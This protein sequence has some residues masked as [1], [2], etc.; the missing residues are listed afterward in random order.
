MFKGYTWYCVFVAMTTES[1]EPE[2]GYMA[3]D[4][5]LSANKGSKKFYTN[6]IY[7]T[8]HAQGMQSLSQKI[9]YTL[10]KC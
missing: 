2:Q 10:Q 4:T 7:V 3:P 8:K 9:T 1:W 6:N 5:E